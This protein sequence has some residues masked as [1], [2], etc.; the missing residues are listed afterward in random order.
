MVLR[1]LYGKPGRF[2]YANCGVDGAIG[3]GVG[4]RLQP[5]LP[6]DYGTDETMA[7][8]KFSEEFTNRYGRPHPE[9]FPGSLDEAIKQSCLKPAKEVSEESSQNMSTRI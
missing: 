6:D 7:A 5:L 9:F 2:Y 4:S 1:I 3:R 8:I